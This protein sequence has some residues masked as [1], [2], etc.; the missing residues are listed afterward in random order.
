MR[1]TILFALLFLLTV[2]CSKTNSSKYDIV[3]TWQVVHCSSGN[4]EGYEY[5][6]DITRVWYWTFEKNGTLKESEETSTGG[7]HVSSTT[8][9]ISGDVITIEDDDYKI[10]EYDSK[11]L[12]IRYDG[13][14]SWLQYKLVR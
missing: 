12:V 4:Y 6:E 5:S 8:W 13:G 2:G 11:T 3:G 9:S 10:K 14:H 1:R 7:V